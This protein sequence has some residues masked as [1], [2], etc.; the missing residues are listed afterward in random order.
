MLLDESLPR[1]L[2]ADLKG[3][4]VTTVKE[5]GFAGLANGEL[6]ARD[7]ANSTYS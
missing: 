2:R 1:D 5:A 4:I 3:H 6:L 7:T